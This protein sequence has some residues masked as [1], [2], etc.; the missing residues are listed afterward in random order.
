MK[1]IISLITLL[2]LA[3]FA[4]GVLAQETELPDP[5]LTPD[6]P[7]YFLETIVEGIGTFFTFGDLKKAER[8]TILATERLAEAQAMAE[9]EKPKL[10]EKTLERYEKQLNKS[11]ARA[12]KAM[13]K[14]ENIEKAA[15]ILANVGKTTYKRLDVLIEVYE[16]V[17]EQ[18]KPAIEN[19]M[20]A[21]LKGHE[22]AV[23]ALK[24]KDALGEV[25]ETVSLPAKVPQEVR[26]TIQRKAQEELIVEKALQGS[27][28]PR[29]L[30]IKAGGPPEMCD[31]I[32]VDGFESFEALKVF[33][34]EVGAPPEAWTSVESKCKEY[35]ATTPDKCF[36]L[37]LISS[38]KAYSSTELKASPAPSLSEEEMEESKIQRGAEEAL[39]KESIQESQHSDVKIYIPG[40][41][42]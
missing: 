14:S 25:P 28:S 24:A 40:E 21:S 37:L 36:R 23:E 2:I 41:N 20:K 38:T 34:I 6:S 1:K 30:C 19:A 33:F 15:E 7:F 16:K 35:G 18:A 12:E 39:R 17:S 8:Y 11:I 3:G 31:K 4:A 10:M 26:E 9:K 5:G 22:K 13:I 27:E 29:E 32:P 42:Q